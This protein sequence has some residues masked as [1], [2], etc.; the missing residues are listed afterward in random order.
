MRPKFHRH[1]IKNNIQSMAI[2]EHALL[3][4]T[5]SYA[6][7]YP[8]RWASLLLDGN[9]T[10]G[11][12]GSVRLHDRLV[13]T[14]PSSAVAWRRFVRIQRALFASRNSSFHSLPWVSAKHLRGICEH[15][16]WEFLGIST[17]LFMLSS[18]FNAQPTSTPVIQKFVHGLSLI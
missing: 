8:Y 9:Y 2:Y 13:S 12:V 17:V 6:R 16:M 5:K 1:N 7:N 18:R 15:F 4:R 3:H 10:N 11:T 14:M